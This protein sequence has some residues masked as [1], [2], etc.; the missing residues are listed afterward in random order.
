[1]KTLARKQLFICKLHIS[2]EDVEPTIMPRVTGTMESSDISKHSVLH[3]LHCQQ[4]WRPNLEG[5]IVQLVCLKIRRQN[6]NFPFCQF[7]PP[8]TPTTPTFCNGHFANN[9]ISGNISNISSGS[10]RPRHMK[11]WWIQHFLDEGHQPQRGGRGANL[12]KAKVS[13]KTGWKW[14]TM[15]RWIRIPGT[16]LG[17]AT[18][19]KPNHF[20]FIRPGVML[21]L[22]PPPAE[23]LLSSQNSSA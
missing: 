11:Q 23:P 3:I 8:N 13:P 9:K 1:M 14:K 2:L 20:V 18:V 22:M 7:Q 21:P 5:I 12:Y 15:D 10:A 17:S 19:Y 16:P 6:R 4:T